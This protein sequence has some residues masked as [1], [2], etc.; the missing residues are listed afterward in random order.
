MNTNLNDIFSKNYDNGNCPVCGTPLSNSV[1]VYTETLKNDQSSCIRLRT[2]RCNHC[3]S[4]FQ[5]KTVTYKTF[6]K[7]TRIKHNNS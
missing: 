3:G 2:Y 7:V 1:Y 5:V 4:N 6:A